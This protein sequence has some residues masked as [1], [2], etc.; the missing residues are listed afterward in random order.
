LLHLTTI[1]RRDRPNRP[2]RER[3]AGSVDFTSVS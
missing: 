2:R 1:E 3:R